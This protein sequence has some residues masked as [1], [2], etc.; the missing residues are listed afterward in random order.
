MA[1]DRHVGPGTYFAP[2]R[3]AVAPRRVPNNLPIPSATPRPAFGRCWDDGAARGS[4]AGTLRRLDAPALLSRAGRSSGAHQV[5]AVGVGAPASTSARSSSNA[6]W[7]SSAVQQAPRLA[8]CGSRR[9]HTLGHRTGAAGAPARRRAPCTRIPC[10]HSA[11]GVRPPR[12][13][14]LGKGRYRYN[15]VELQLGD[16][17]GRTAAVRSCNHMDAAGGQARARG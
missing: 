2:L 14:K 16:G 13:Y 7:Q 4:R 9:C 6:C 8:F 15:Q 12:V 10:A 17:G 5:S 11:R 3:T 1:L